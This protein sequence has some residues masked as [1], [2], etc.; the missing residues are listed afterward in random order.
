MH[1]NWIRTLL[2][3]AMVTALAGCTTSKEQLMPHGDRTMQDIW[4]QQAGEGGSGQVARK[5]HGHEE[6]HPKV[7]RRIIG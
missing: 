3:A 5:R 6:S 1:S 2:L 7:G 4:H